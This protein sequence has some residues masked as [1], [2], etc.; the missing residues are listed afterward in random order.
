DPAGDAPGEMYRGDKRNILYRCWKAPSPKAVLVLVHG[1]GA[2]SLWWE[3]FSEF[4]LRGGIS[5]YAI[6]LAEYG[7]FGV[8]SKDILSLHR[9]I[10]KENPGKNIF[11]VGESMGAIISLLILAARPDLSSGLV[12]LSPALKSALN[13]TIRDYFAIF[14]P[15]LYNPQKKFVMPYDISMCTRDEEHIKRAEEE[16]AGGI[17]AT[18]RILFDIIVS[19]IRLRMSKNKFNGSVLFLIPERDAIIDSDATRRFFEKLKSPDKT[20]IEYPG[21]YHS[22]SIDIGRENVFRDILKWLED[23]L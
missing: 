19:Q 9:I 12:C 1:I 15:L 23:R 2:H 17:S 5:S 20:L 8:Y 3:S 4:F 10:R 6:E 14:A 13:F 11:L 7:S 16:G 22:I 21:M 18:S